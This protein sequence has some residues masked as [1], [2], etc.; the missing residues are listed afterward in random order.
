MAEKFKL[1]TRN[2]TGLRNKIKTTDITL[3]VATAYNRLD[4]HERARF[5]QLTQFLDNGASVKPESNAV[6]AER[7]IELDRRLSQSMSAAHSQVESINGLL[8]EIARL[9]NQVTEL[10]QQLHH[11]EAKHSDAM[12]VIAVYR[13][14]EGDMQDQ[15]CKLQVLNAE[16]DALVESMKRKYHALSLDHTELQNVLMNLG[17]NQNNA[18]VP[19]ER[20]QEGY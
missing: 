13:R 16:H 15:L 12:G 14:K 7:I 1:V 5:S 4:E 6:L 18:P 19:A 3:G 17:K 11:A 9:R 10:N 20:G 8:E 2:D